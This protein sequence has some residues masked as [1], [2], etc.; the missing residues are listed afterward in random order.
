MP[1]DLPRSKR[2]LYTYIE[3]ETFL[4]KIAKS[5]CIMIAVLA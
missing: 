3:G 2:F 5:P 4:K 1:Q